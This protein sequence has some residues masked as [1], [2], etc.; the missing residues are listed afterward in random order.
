MWI[1]RLV[2]ARRTLKKVLKKTVEMDL[3]STSS[4]KKAIDAREKDGHDLL[5]PSSAADY[6][7]TCAKPGDII[8]RYS[9]FQPMW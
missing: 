6:G 4:S 3:S 9:L 7:F 2:S 1:K 8:C 5:L